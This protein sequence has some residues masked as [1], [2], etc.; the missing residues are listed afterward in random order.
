M[1]E[2]T[3]I[4]GNKWVIK[5]EYCQRTKGSMWYVNTKEK[6]I[7]IINLDPYSETS[8]WLIRRYIEQ[9]KI[10]YTRN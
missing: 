3:L 8:Q 1:I 2:E 7:G 4:N 5:Y 6:K 9:A 10:Q